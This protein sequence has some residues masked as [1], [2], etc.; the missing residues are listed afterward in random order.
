MPATPIVIRRDASPEELNIVTTTIY[1][2]GAS[3]TPGLT[4]ESSS[5]SSQPSVPLAPIIGG[6]L[7]GVCLALI[8]V[9]GWSW[10]GSCI[11]RKEE[12]KRKE[13]VS[14]SPVQDLIRTILTAILA[15]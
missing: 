13:E 2:G 5:S 8:V 3:P 15:L 4:T 7:G 11:E 10:W 14:T 6:V 12:E 1:S 9:L